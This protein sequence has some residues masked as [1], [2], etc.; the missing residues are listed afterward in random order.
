MKVSHR[1]RKTITII[2]TALAVLIAGAGVAYAANENSLT[3]G[4]TDHTIYK[5]GRDI[6]I[7]GSVNGDIFCAGQT[8]TIDAQVNG[9]VLCA[10]QTV[11]IHG[12]V[13]GNVRAAGQTITIDAKVG[14]NASL[15]GQDI[16]LT[17]NAQIGRD[18]SA[19]GQT[20]TLAGTVG[21]DLDASGNTLTLNGQ[22]G[23]NVSATVGDKVDIQHSA[24]IKGNLTYTAPHQV[25]Q[26]I[27]TAQVNGMATYHQQI[28]HRPGHDGWPAWWRL[29]GLVAIG[30][31]A[32]VLV[33]LFPQLFR[34]WN[35][36]ATTSFGWA[37]LT[38]FIAM[39]AVPIITIVAFVTFVGVPVGIFLL[40]LW[41]L[42]AL[43][44]APVAMYFVG[45]RI[46][47]SL[48]PVLIMLIGVLVLGIT[49]LLP[50]MGPLL[51]LLA[52]WLGTG[53]LLLS[54]KHSY[55]RPNYA[56]K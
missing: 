40:L 42:A 7:T 14:N 52:Y 49:E 8:V 4:N 31:L 26:A 20:I 12:D 6:T 35:A 53:V 19:S 1:F 39:F 3:Q 2:A 50:F 11:T 13:S 32:V 22:I 54:L 36:V 27:N 16:T 46:A 38:G 33:A 37:L 23:R 56:N 15:A 18:I 24:L 17:Q 28:N 44:S 47:S 10:G 30:V 29:Y 45:S 55:K 51:G 41:I 34:R 5:F 25:R 9:D 43:L 48:H 21:R